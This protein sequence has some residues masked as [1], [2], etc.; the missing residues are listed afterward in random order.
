MD[1]LGRSGDSLFSVL[2]LNY[3]IYKDLFTGQNL[4][5][6]RH[7][8]SSV[9]DTPEA[10]EELS[11]QCRDQ[12]PQVST[13]IEKQK[14]EDREVMKRIPNLIEDPSRFLGHPIDMVI[15]HLS[16]LHFGKFNKVEPDSRQLAFTI[17]KLATDHNKI[18]PDV[19]VVSGDVSSVASNDEFTQFKTFCSVLSH[20]LWG[21]SHPERILVVPGNH[22]VS[23]KENRVS[24]HLSAFAANFADDSVCITPFGTDRVEF[25]GGRISVKRINPN[26]ATVPPF[27]VIHDK[28]KGIEFILFV[29][30]YFSGKIPDQVVTALKGVGEA[31]KDLLI[32][33]RHD[34]GAVNQEYLFNISAYLEKRATTAL[35][36][37]HHNPIQYGVETCQNRFAPQLLETLWNKR[38][39]ILLHGHIHQTESKGSSRPV[40]NG[41]SYPLPATTLCSITTAGSGRG[42]NVHLVGPSSSERTIDTLVWNFS[43]SLGFNPADV[44][45]RYRFTLKSDELDVTHC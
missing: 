37:M 29:S 34:E 12:Y 16:D 28:E 15:W 2:E 20:A 1:Y 39:P 10:R 14:A 30:G 25:A 17:A 6:G 13:I 43:E 45:L 5:T 24:D 22:D 4:N 21:G 31:D 41:L 36:V 33:L 26:P 7:L 19:I 38:V 18:H 8:L 27:A 23:W 44:I 9:I 3:K 11:L 42:L 35:G 32:L 40:A